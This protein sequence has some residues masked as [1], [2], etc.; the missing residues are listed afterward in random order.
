MAVL[1]AVAVLSVAVLLFVNA[2]LHA[3]NEN[4]YLARKVGFSKALTVTNRARG[5]G[6]ER[7]PKYFFAWDLLDVNH[8]VRGSFQI[9]DV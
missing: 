2:G 6:R 5:V 4:S 7:R 3:L 1:V 9:A 8:L